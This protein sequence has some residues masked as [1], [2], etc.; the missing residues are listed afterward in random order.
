M[1]KKIKTIVLELEETDWLFNSA[2]LSVG[3]CVQLE[4]EDDWKGYEIK[5]ISEM[6]RPK[7]GA[8]R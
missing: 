8:V 7:T 2:T 3:R 5:R 4:N 1:K 6:R